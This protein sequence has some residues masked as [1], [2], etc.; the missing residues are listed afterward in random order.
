MAVAVWVRE[1]RWSAGDDV[2][3]P[4][5]TPAGRMIVPGAFLRLAI[6]WPMHRVGRHRAQVAPPRLVVLNG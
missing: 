2:T 6:R 3:E 4:G 1:V 5:A